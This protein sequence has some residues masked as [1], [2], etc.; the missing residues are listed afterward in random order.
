M[1]G[2]AGNDTYIVDLKTNG[3]LEDKIKEVAGGGTDTLE[4]RGDATLSKASTLTLATNLEK[5]DASQ[6]GNTLLNLKGNASDNILTGNE[7]ANILTG[8]AGNDTLI[9]GDGADLLIGGKGK[10]TY[11][12]IETETNS[13]TDTVRIAKGDSLV[14]SFDVVNGFKLGEDKL[15]L[16]TNKIAA[17]AAVVDGTDSG[18]IGSHSISN[19]LISFDDINIH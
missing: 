9:G 14:G 10:D 19:G 13:A 6:T 7:A 16:A 1:I 2:G 8:G 4:L 3:Q 18:G 5:L 11:D 17:N 12:L 15:D